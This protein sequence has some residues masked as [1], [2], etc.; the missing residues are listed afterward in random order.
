MDGQ[1]DCACEQCLFQL[2]GKKAFA[3]DL[4]KSYMLD[5][6]T[7]GFDDYKFRSDTQTSEFLL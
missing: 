3:F 1:I 5:L 7:F 6:V 2:F 4:I